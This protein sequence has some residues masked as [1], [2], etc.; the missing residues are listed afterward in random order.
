MRS[1]QILVFQV[2]ICV[3]LSIN[4]KTCVDYATVSNAALRAA[5]A[6]QVQLKQ[7]RYIKKKYSLHI[8]PSL[9]II[10]SVL[11]SFH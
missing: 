6:L 7:F 11:P 9:L 4:D 8:L 2:D 5:M 1:L 3:N 10:F